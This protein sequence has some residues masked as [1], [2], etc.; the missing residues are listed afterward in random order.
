MLIPASITSFIVFN[1]DLLKG[2]AGLDKQKPIKR[3][4]SKLYSFAEI[5]SLSQTEDD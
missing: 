5:Y 1:R 3:L 2:K 4:T